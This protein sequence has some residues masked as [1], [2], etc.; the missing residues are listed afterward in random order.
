MRHRNVAPHRWSDRGWAIWLLLG[1]AVVAMIAMFGAHALLT[2]DTARK[3]ARDAQIEAQAVEAGARQDARLA[4][5]DAR[6]KERA[7]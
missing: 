3:D 4:A 2:R 7:R 5:E 1:A 6:R